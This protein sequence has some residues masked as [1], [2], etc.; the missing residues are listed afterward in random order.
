MKKEFS[1]QS[2]IDEIA[3]QWARLVL[4]QITKKMPDVK[5]ID[6]EQKAI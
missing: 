2:K 4:A 1:K 5:K 3:E 6:L